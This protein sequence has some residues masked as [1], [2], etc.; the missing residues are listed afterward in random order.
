MTPWY[1][2]SGARRDIARAAQLGLIHVGRRSERV[3]GGRELALR[4][5]RLSPWTHPGWALVLAAG[6]VLAVAVM[7]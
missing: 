5:M 6:V 7:R 1:E 3:N 4:Q 2:R